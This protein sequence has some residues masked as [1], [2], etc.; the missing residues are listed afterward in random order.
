[1]FAKASS[2]ETPDEFL[3]DFR[4][5]HRNAV[6]YNPVTDYEGCIYY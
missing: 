2:Y 1:M 5:I 3:N 6:E 4:L